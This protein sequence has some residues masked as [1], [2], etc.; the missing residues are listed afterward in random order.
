MKT[1]RELQRDVASEL[2]RDPSVDAGRI[3]VEVH[4]GSVTLAG[5]ANSFARKRRGQPAGFRKAVDRTAIAA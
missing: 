4:A 1:D 3:D 2:G 5:L